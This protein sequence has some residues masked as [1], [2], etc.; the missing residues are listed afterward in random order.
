[1]TF[2]CTWL[3]CTFSVLTP[4]CGLDTL[5]PSP[6]VGTSKPSAAWRRVF[7]HTQADPSLDHTQADPSP[8]PLCPAWV[9]PSLGQTWSFVL[10]HR[11]HASL[12]T[13]LVLG[14]V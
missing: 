14:P 2:I 4:G 5:L 8:R 7:D 12:S 13:G 9:V 3:N 10:K 6:N 1:M 11:L